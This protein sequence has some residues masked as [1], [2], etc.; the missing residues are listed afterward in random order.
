MIVYRVQDDEGRW[1]W[2][3]GLSRHWVR[4]RDDHAN[5][6]PWMQEFGDVIPRS[7][8]PFGNH[9]GCACKTI[10]QLRRWFSADEYETLLSFGFEAVQMEVDRVLAESDIQLVFQRSRPLRAG[11]EPV[12]LYG[13]N[14]GGE[15]TGAA[16]CDRSPRP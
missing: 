2:R 14:A 8:W 12:S 16:L 3:P 11:V 10:E 13:H 15:A 1:P 6:R 4:E 7:G 5:L 9:F